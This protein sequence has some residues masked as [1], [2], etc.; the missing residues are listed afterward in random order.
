MCW[1]GKCQSDEHRCF[2]SSVATFIQPTLVVFSSF[3]SGSLSAAT[4]LIGG[5]QS[6]TFFLFLSPARTVGVG[7][8][9][10]FRCIKGA[11]P[12]LADKKRRAPRRVS[13]TATVKQNLKPENHFP[14]IRVIS[15]V[16][17][18]G[19]WSYLGPPFVKRWPLSH[20]QESVR[21]KQSRRLTTVSMVLWMFRH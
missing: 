14:S 3:P 12:A 21:R 20:S 8:F 13:H 5:G 4:E 17:K 19:S 7:T 16:S 9:F 15:F 2:C 11:A 18:W 1:S 10:F 6:M